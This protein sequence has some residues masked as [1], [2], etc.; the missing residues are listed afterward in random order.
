VCGKGR[1][2]DHLP[3]LFPDSKRRSK[4]MPAKKMKKAAKKKK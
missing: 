3:V 2:T 1:W 4:L